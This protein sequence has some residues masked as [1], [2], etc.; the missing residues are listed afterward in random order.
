MMV[1]DGYIITGE[2]VENYWLV[3]VNHQIHGASNIIINHHSPSL[4]MVIDG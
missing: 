4:T 2:L 1:R 3:M